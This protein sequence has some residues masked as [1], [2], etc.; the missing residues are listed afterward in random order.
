MRNSFSH[1][2]S[3]L[4]TCEK[5]PAD[6]KAKIEELKK[7]RNRQKSLLKPGNH[8]LFIDRVWE[9]MHNGT[10]AKSDTT[11]LADSS[12]SVATGSSADNVNNDL[13]EAF[14]T[15]E[16]S[17][18]QDGDRCLTSDLTF[19]TLL[20][21]TPYTMLSSG[22]SEI[23]GFP[24]FVCSHCNTRKFFT[25]SSEHLS[26]LLLTISNHM[27]TCQS[28]PKSA[29]NLITRFRGTHDKQLKQ[30]SSDD[31]AK[32]MQ[33]VWK[34]LVSASKKEQKK[35]AIKPVESEENVCYLPVDKTKPVV[36]PEDENLVTAFTYFTMQQVRPCNLNR[37]ENGARSQF[38]D[39]FP[40]LECIYCAENDDGWSSSSG[41]ASNGRKFF[42]RTV[43]ILAGE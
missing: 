1:I 21:V 15:T 25:T 43:E 3:H 38:A 13:V 4:A 37:A 6:V 39:G 23:I 11:S 28:C 31:H 12:T 8:K 5:C 2:P 19:F 9:R 33:N 20:Q 30:V 17:L 42:Y 27:Q 32:C 26:G 29:R 35:N 16:M 14:K 22:N 18:V 7:L 34:R 36:T 10:A 24:G 40:G 41:N